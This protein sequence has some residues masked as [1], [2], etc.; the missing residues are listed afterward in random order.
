MAFSFI[1]QCGVLVTAMAQIF[2]DDSTPPT[3]SCPAAI[4][5]NADN[6][7]DVNVPLSAWIG[8]AAISDNCGVEPIIHN[9]SAQL[10]T[11][12]EFEITRDITFILSD[13]CGNQSPACSSALTILAD[14]RPTLGCPDPLT[15]ECGDTS[16][17]SIVQDWIASCSATSASGSPLTF[18]NDLDL[19]LLQSTNCIS[20]IEV[21]FDVSDQCAPGVFLTASC[22]AILS[23]QDNTPPSI[24]C[25]P[26]IE[27]S[28][29]DPGNI[30]ILE[31]WISTANATDNCG[32]PAITSD[33]TPSTDLSSL[34]YP[35]TVSFSALDQC[36]LSTSCISRITTD[37]ASPSINCPSDLN[38]ECGDPG[39]DSTVQAYLASV[40]ATDGT[41]A[42]LNVTVDF[43]QSILN[44]NACFQTTIASFTAEDAQGNILT[45]QS[46][47]TINDT[48]AP[49]YLNGCPDPLRLFTSQTAA[50]KQQAYQDWIAAVAVSDCNSYTLD[51][52]FDPSTLASGGN[53]DDFPISFS[54]VDACGWIAS[55]CASAIIIT[56]DGGPATNDGLVL[57]EIMY[58]SPGAD[59]DFIEL[60][61]NSD[62][63][64]SIEGY[65]IVEGVRYIFPNFT[66]APRELIVLTN[67]SCNFREVYQPAFNFYE[68]DSGT[69]LNGG[70]RIA[71]VN[72]ARDTIIDLRYVD[73]DPWPLLAAG[74][75]RSIQLCDANSDMAD[76]NN[77][78]SNDTQTSISIIPDG[79]LVFA[80][81]GVLGSCKQSYDFLA[82]SFNERTE[83]DIDIVQFGLYLE[84]SRPD[85][86]HYLV[87]AVST[88]I[89][90]QDYR[91]R[92]D[93]V[94]FAP[95]QFRSNISIELF[96]DEIAEDV[97]LIC[98]DVSGIQNDTNY[99]CL[100]TFLILDDD[101]PLTRELEMRG[102]I[103]AE[104][105]KAVELHVKRDLPRTRFPRYGL[106]VT[107]NGGGNQAIDYLLFSEAQ[108]AG[109]CIYVT[110]DTVRFKKFFGPQSSALLIE[111]RLNFNGNDA[112]EL[113]ENGE[114]I[115]V[116][117]F[118][119]VNGTG[120][121][122]EYTDSWAKKTTPGNRTTFEENNWSYG[123]VGALEEAENNDATDNPYPL[124]CLATSTESPSRLDLEIYP[125]PTSGIIQISGLKGHAVMR[126]LD[127]NGRELMQTD[128]QKID[129]S[130][131]SS[132]IYFIE[133]KS[134]TQTVV[135]KVVV[136]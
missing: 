129:L 56:D 133:I 93:T 92:S 115:D 86:Q 1:D 123:G 76:P 33:L 51:T 36:G 125:N 117:G 127:M 78:Q 59:I 77:W 54:L 79:E 88:S 109:S 61:N 19:A 65:E 14:K 47:V 108:S 18:M 97:E 27:I 32:D 10:F 49:L 101:G 70:E 107:S 113:Y 30:Q 31:N 46:N 83:E 53:A 95:G 102:I 12:C 136:H 28:L 114:I 15:L 24:I 55:S 128:H 130:A 35:H 94:V 75:G 64:L 5:I 104:D 58:N 85:T 13:Q 124:E 119:D 87:R 8:S 80:N 106:G 116:F 50:E 22:V 73:S 121:A 3:L 91:L 103:D 43:D 100:S 34:I 63:S 37:Q 122:W 29:G 4:T 71:V 112:L 17:S 44:N 26:D 7:P 68:W 16:N 25:P 81:P 11:G 40:T 134:G 60:L 89:N 52:D 62:D 120:T 66:L 45:C 2:I 74:F 69:L 41:G 23:I 67:D 96:D 135:E 21:I 110:N 84:T 72:S 90:D 20:E 132:G 98:F 126:V 99:L 131:M 42:A 6:V 9:Y 39:N 82:G 118:P 105:F 38:L 48:D 57:T 111:D